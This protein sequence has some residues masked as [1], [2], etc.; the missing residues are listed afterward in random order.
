MALLDFRILVLMVFG[1][2]ISRTDCVMVMDG[3]LVPLDRFATLHPP[4]ITAILN[5]LDNKI[6]SRS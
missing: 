4:P 2:E 3:S 5:E 1:I 6:N